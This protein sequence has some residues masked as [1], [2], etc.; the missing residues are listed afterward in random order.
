MLCQAIVNNRFKVTYGTSQ[1]LN[2]INWYQDARE[3]EW[4]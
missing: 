2:G 3:D 4:C 1:H